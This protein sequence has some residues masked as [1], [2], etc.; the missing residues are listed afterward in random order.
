[1][2]GYFICVQPETPCQP[3]H[4]VAVTEVTLQDLAALGITP[5]SVS[6]AVGIG[7]ALVFGIAMLGFGLGVAL[8]MVRSI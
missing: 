4:Q 3:V 1:M 8:R 2:S 5:G 7:F 6:A